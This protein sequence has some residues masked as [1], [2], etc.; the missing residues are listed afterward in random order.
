M[1]LMARSKAT[2]AMTLEWVNCR[3]LPY[4]SKVFDQRALQVPI[5]V[6]IR[7]ARGARL[8]QRVHDLAIDIKLELTGSRVADANGARAFVSLEPR[9]FP[10]VEPPL[11]RKPV[12]D[13]H[14]CRI[15][16][17]GAPQPPAPSGGFLMEA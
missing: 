14:L 17:D 11:A 8:I 12:H 1:V 2:Q 7:E 10:F 3:L 5:G 6:V 9:D 15:A 16:G 4:G 13:L